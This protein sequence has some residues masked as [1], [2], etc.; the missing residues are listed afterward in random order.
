MQRYTS[1]ERISVGLRQTASDLQCA[2]L[3]LVDAL[4]FSTPLP[5][6]LITDIR[7]IKEQIGALIKQVETCQQHVIT[8]WHENLSLESN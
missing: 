6:A 7:T 5:A 3:H 4:H 1:H 8:H 2:D